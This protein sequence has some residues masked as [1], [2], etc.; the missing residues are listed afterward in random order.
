MTI[1]PQKKLIGSQ[2]MLE[3]PA[4]KHC[5][6]WVSVRSSNFGFLQPWEPRWDAVVL[7]PSGYK[8]IL[9]KFTKHREEWRNVVYFII[10]KSDNQ[11]VGGITLGNIRFGASATAQLG[12]WMGKEYTRNGYMKETLAVIVRYAFTELYFERLEAYCMENNRPS[13]NLLKKCN[14][15]PEGEARGFLEIN[16][17]REDHLIFSLLKSDLIDIA[18]QRFQDY[19]KKD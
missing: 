18:Q 2:I 3:L 13:I 16:G 10:R 9:K 4:K 11:L 14:F 5:D 1:K 12:Y 6:A 17:F 7:T 15:K 8:K 19:I